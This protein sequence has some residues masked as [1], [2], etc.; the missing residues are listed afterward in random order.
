VVISLLVEAAT[1]GGDNAVESLLGL[2]QSL[3]GLLRASLGV[4]KLLGADG[5]GLLLLGQA[6]GADCRPLLL[7]LKPLGGSGGTVQVGRCLRASSDSRCAF[8]L[9]LNLLQPTQRLIQPAQEG[10]YTDD[11][12]GFVSHVGIGV[13]RSGLSR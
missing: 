2:G 1:G 10:F 9:L 6:L 7:L 13:R 4:G 11:E 5:N 12:F 3:R 8:E